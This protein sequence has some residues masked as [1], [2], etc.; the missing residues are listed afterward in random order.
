M[1]GLNF[2]FSDAEVPTWWT[3]IPNK[4]PLLTGWLAGPVVKKS[5]ADDEGLMRLAFQSLC[6]LFDAQEKRVRKEVRA[7]KVI[8]WHADPFSMGA[9]AYSTLNT[10]AAIDMLSHP[11]QETIYFAGE[12]FYQGAE[13]GTVEAA[14]A[15][16]NEAA[17]NVI[18]TF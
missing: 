5:P 3:Q 6:Y 1:P 18:R 11:V 17:A 13:M 4:V 9:Y 10:A 14:L 2:L 7:I 16:G 15:S 12:A 8:N